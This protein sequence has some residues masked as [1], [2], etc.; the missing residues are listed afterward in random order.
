M[1]VTVARWFAQMMVAKMCRACAS[2]SSLHEQH[3]FEYIIFPSLPNAPPQSFHVAGWPRCLVG[4]VVVVV[5]VVVVRFCA[6]TS[7]LCVRVCV[8]LARAR[9]RLACACACIDVPSCGFNQLS[10]LPRFSQ[11][12]WFASMGWQQEALPNRACSWT[13]R[14][15]RLN[16][17]PRWTLTA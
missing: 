17:C 16:S 12:S 13:P 4:V 11:I 2:C 3:L 5:V 15:R 1:A 8:L 9:A 14:R 10:G 7:C 6:C